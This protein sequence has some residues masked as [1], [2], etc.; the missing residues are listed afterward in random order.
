MQQAFT[1]MKKVLSRNRVVRVYRTVYLLTLMGYGIFLQLKG[2]PENYIA[3]GE[4]MMYMAV[5]GYGFFM[6][7]GYEIGYLSHIL[8]SRLQPGHSP[9]PL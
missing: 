5:I 2:N 3:D 4:A 7:M 8:S 1:V 9:V 6:Y